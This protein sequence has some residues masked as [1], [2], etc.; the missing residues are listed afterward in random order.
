MKYWVFIVT[1]QKENGKVIPGREILKTRLEDGIWGLGERTP[2]RKNLAAGDKVVFY[3]GNPTK[4]FVA[5]ATL[6]SK[7]FQL[8]ADER[9]RFSHDK[10]L[11]TT[12]YGVYLED[13]QLFENPIPA[14]QVVDSLSF[15]ENKEYWYSYF[16]GGTREIFEIDYFVITRVSPATLTEQ[17]KATA[18][19]ESESQFALEAHLEEFMFNNWNKID[20][21][22]KLSL[23]Q[24]DE[25]NGRQYPAETWSIDFLCKDAHDNLVVIELK[26]GKTSDATVG[27]LLRYIGWV[28]EN[29]AKKDQEVRGIIIAHE[30]DDALKYSASSLPHV[31]VMTYQVDFRLQ[32]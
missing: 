4:S 2:N 24:D 29:I 14:E 13:I 3:E 21:G 23:Y 12:E 1:Q 15:I 6:K 25:Q 5:S 7:S 10:A 22:E 32:G 30:I 8:S 9:E 26:R 18:D 20:F 17:I 31:R 28:K 19:L 11:F 27:Q 16:Q